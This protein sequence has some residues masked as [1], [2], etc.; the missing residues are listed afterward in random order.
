MLGEIRLRWLARQFARPSGWAGRWLI[1]P[2]LDL[3]SAEMQRA[4]LERLEIGVADDVLEVG[5][6]GGALLAA[7]RARTSGSVY[8]V[9][10]AAQMVARARQRLGAGV[11]LFEASAERIPLQDRVADKAVSLNSLYFWLDPEAAFEELA[12]VLRPGG[13]L[14]LG[15]EPPEELARW[16]G[17]RFGF[18]AFSRA[19]VEAMLRAAGFGSIACVEGKGRKP[20]RFLTLSAERPRANG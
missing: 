13:R 20:D 6:G 3:I 10:P 1:A 11:T 19:E 18:R 7:V 16:R 2:W 15:F 8:G 14:V 9:D 5:F 17:S 4:A 12:R